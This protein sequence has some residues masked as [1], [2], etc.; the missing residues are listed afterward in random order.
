MLIH[1]S[2][3]TLTQMTDNIRDTVAVII[4]IWKHIFVSWLFIFWPW[5]PLWMWKIN[6]R[7][8]GNS[9]RNRRLWIHSTTFTLF[10]P[11]PLWIIHELVMFIIWILEL[12][13][14]ICLF[15]TLTLW[16]IQYLHPPNGGP[17]TN[18]S[19]I[20]VQPKYVKYFQLSHLKCQKFCIN[21]DHN[22]M[23]I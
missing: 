4:S 18:P 8:F 15:Y 6:F 12:A 3:V 23:V 17:T 20:H 10:L 5:A 22:E 21:L 13:I 11:S 14:A 7:T 9:F 16:I 1:A 2:V 19:G